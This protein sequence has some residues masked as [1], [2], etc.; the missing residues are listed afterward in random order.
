[1]V[2][3]SRPNRV[4]ISG[5]ADFETI[6]DYVFMIGKDQPVIALGAVR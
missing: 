4:V 3:S 6:A 1:V 5:E 2:K